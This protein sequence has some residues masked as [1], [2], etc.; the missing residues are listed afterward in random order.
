MIASGIGDLSKVLTTTFSVASH[1]F[2]TFDALDVAQTLH[3]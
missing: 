1:I 3:K 2:S